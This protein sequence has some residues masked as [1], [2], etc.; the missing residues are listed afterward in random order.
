MLKSVSF[1]NPASSIKSNSTTGILQITGPAAGSTRVM[2]VPDANFT[3]ARIDAAQSFT[4][5]Q[6][7]A[8]GNIVIG[9]A[10]KGVD[11]TANGGDIL[12]QYDEGTWLPNLQFGGA[13]VGITYSTQQ[14][15]FTKIGNVVTASCIIALSSKG[16]ST[17]LAT[18]SNMPFASKAN[19][20]GV[21]LV[22]CYSGFASLGGV[23]QATLAGGTTAY[24]LFNQSTGQGAYTDG[25]FTDS[26]IFQFCM[27]YL[28]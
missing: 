22:N 12:S 8:T 17:G 1:A 11:F 9:T 2:T 13:N 16:T 14:G 4:G 27:T 10:G 7:L 5:D 24:F 15:V 19:T 20:C 6:T 3:V 23:T 25:N 26:S 28:A 18:I 21:A